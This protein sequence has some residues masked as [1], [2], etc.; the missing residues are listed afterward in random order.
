M[1]KFKKPE[2]LDG[3]KLR[4]ELNAAGV[5]ISYEMESVA[6]DGEGNLYLDI[7]ENDVA[8]A[9]LIVSNHSGGTLTNQ[10]GN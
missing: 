2:S 1:I 5:V 7:N 10:G 4:D 6:D 8:T 9:T 3:A